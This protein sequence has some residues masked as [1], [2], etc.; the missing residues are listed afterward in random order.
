VTAVLALLACSCGGPVFQH[1]LLWGTT[2]TAGVSGVVG[3]VVATRRA[4]RRA[5]DDAPDGAA[6]PDAG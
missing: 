4:R 6:R 3:G 1:V 5:R 2:T